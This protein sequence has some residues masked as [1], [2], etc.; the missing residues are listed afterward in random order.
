MPYGK[1]QWQKE[2]RKYIYLPFGY[3]I[4]CMLLDS[5]TEEAKTAI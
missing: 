5:E 4:K 2:E 1:W 3:Y